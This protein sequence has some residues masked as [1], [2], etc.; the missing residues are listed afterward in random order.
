MENTQEYQGNSMEKFE[1]QTEKRNSKPGII[2]AGVSM[3]KN[4]KGWL[5]S[6]KKHVNKYS[7][8]GATTD[9][10]ESFLKPL[11]ARQPEDI[12]IH[13]GTNDLSRTSA[14]QIYIYTSIIF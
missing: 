8:L 9:E 13:I 5:M 6:R 1:E 14:R 11:I 2:I 12:I 4:V 7:F 10:M 3:V